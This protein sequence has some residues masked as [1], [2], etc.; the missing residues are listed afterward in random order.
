MVVATRP[1]SID[2]MGPDGEGYPTKIEK[3][4]F[5]TDRTE[6]LVPIGSQTLKI[7]VPHRISFA[8]GDACKVR[9]VSPMW[10]PAEDEAAEKE[11]QRRQLV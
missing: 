2:L 6:Y 8:E 7:Q 5:L 4:I 9:F 11:R 3:R 10:Y 1:N